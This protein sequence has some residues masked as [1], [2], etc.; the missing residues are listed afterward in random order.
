MK[1]EHGDREFF[2][3]KLTVHKQHKLFEMECPECTFAKHLSQRQSSGLCGRN[4]VLL[5]VY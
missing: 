5:K 3:I 4:K 2:I 1:G